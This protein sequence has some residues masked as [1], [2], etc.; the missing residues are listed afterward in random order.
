M[1]EEIRHLP[2]FECF[3]DSL[4]EGGRLGQLIFHVQFQALESNSSIRTLVIL[5]R[6]KQLF[7][8]SSLWRI[9]KSSIQLG[10]DQGR[11]QGEKAGTGKR[12]RPTDLGFSVIPTVYPFFSLSHE[13]EYIE[14]GI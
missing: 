9:R 11:R 10:S 1:G 8:W 5:I 4:S 12:G 2:P 13:V 14:N 7:Q 6:R 3:K